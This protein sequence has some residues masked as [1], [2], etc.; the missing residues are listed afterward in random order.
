ML[1]RR[2]L[3]RAL[4]RRVRG[5]RRAT[6]AGIAFLTTI[7][8]G[9]AAPLSAGAGVK[10]DAW[11]PS[12]WTGPVAGPPV[13]GT[14]LPPAAVPAIAQPLPEGY[15]VAPEYE[16]QAQ[17]D[18]APKPGTQKLADL[19]KATYG[20]DQTVWIPRACDVGGQSEHK[21]G[22]ALDWMTSVRDPQQRANAEAFL[23]WLLGPDQF[24]N[25]YGNA[26]RLGVMYI[27]WNDR[28]WRG[29]DIKRGWT[30]LKGCFSTPQ[31]GSDTTCHRNH[32]H[33][34]LTW[35]G[36]SGRTSF[37]DGTPMDGPYCDKARSS[38]SVAASGR[39]ADV[40]PVD[41]VRVLGTRKAIGVPERCRLEQDRYSGDSHRIYAKV[42]G[43]GGVP[44]SGVAAV[45]VQV[46]AMGSNAPSKIRIWSPGESQSQTVVKVPM[47]MDAVGTAVVPVSTDG[48]I[49]L[50]TTA[51]ATDLAVDVVGY[52]P[53]GDQ[54]N[55]TDATPG[56]S[57]PMGEEAPP[58][59]A[60]AP[61][62]TP[63]T[64]SGPSFDPP[65]EDEFI[66]IGA[67]VGYES[68]AQGPLQPGEERTVG[69]AGVPGDATSALVLVT[70]REATKRGKVRIATPAAKDAGAVL[71]FPKKGVRTAVMVVPVAGSQVT[72]V[73]SKRA[74]VQLRVEVLG[75]AIHGKPVKVRSVPKKRVVKAALNPAEPL[76]IGP[77]TGV[78]GLP[79]RQKKVTGVILQVQTKTKGSDGGSLKVYPVDGTAPDTRSAPIVPGQK[80]TS[81]VVTELGTDG[82]VAVQSSTQAKVRAKVVG[83]IKRAK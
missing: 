28:I 40:V 32:I 62:P 59:A 34:S 67:E 1:P 4:C 3:G 12:T 23:A 71:A 53:S 47:N 57:M 55:K 24:G 65:L 31:A 73:T 60:P 70:T 42:T 2:H 25:P 44:A 72:F 46:T 63:Q 48:T 26:M 80:Y 68:T 58:A 5:R 33:I 30:E 76:V 77:L 16:G 37:W 81:L 36:A 29:Y 45:S 66:S 9:L 41:P 64:P 38:A 13:P 49:A 35:D 15:D 39:A 51:G 17:C 82:K 50:A 79:K 61:A 43:Q 74:A 8:V 21:E 83:W 10:G 54:P 7:A 19:I 78:A 75:Y 69:L 14:N 18:P 27:G 56:P 6:T 22:R 11:E 52:Y 20:Q